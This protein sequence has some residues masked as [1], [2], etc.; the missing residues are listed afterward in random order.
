MSTHNICFYRELMKIILQLSSN[1]HLI[2]FTANSDP[3]RHILDFKQVKIDCYEVHS[4]FLKVFGLYQTRYVNRFA[5]YIS[6][7]S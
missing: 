1:T 6:I 7:Y 3:E 2:C 5:G 4:V